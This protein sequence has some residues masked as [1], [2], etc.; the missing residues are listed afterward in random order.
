[1]KK[2]GFFVLGGLLL[3]T[4]FVCPLALAADPGATDVMGKLTKDNPIIVDKAG[5][6]IRLLAEVNGKYFFQPTRHAVVTKGGSNGDKSVLAAF[7]EPQAFCD[8]LLQIGAKPGENMTL[9]NKETTR[10]KGDAL[11]VTVTWPGAKKSYT[12]DEVI[13][14]SNKKP[15]VMRFG[16]NLAT[17][18][19]KK[20]GCLLCLDSCPVGI[21]SNEAYTY[22]AVEK[23]K[24]VTFMGNK[25]VLPKDGTQVVVTI[26][27]KK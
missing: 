14:D 9:A 6:T 7:A 23:R 10:V 16:G 4:L 18:K 20:T 5:K 17:A 12:L 11:D 3:L 19:D 24:E 8:G 27:L 13:K 21:V 26:K 22:G 15:I 1:M 25:D 2:T